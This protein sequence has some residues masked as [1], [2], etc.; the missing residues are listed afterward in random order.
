MDPLL[1][2]KFITTKEARELSGYTSD[3]LARLAR[4]G[5]LIG[6]RVGN[7]W[8]IEIESLTEFLDHQGNDKIVRARALARAREAEY[9]AH[10]STA[11]R[12]TS[13]LANK[14]KTAKHVDITQVSLRSHVVA[15][16]IAFA[17]IALGAAIAKSAALPKVAADAVSIA[18]EISSGFD[19]AFLDGISSN[20]VAN[21]DAAKNSEQT[22]PAHLAIT[23]PTTSLV[24]PASPFLANVAIAPVATGTAPIST[25]ETFHAKT[26]VT[27][28]FLATSQL[29][30]Y[31][32]TQ[33]YFALGFG[34]YSEIIKSLSIYETCIEDTAVG[35]FHFGIASRDF[36]AA[37]PKSAVRADVA[38]GNALIEATH[39]LIHA[40]VILAYWIAATAPES[41]HATVSF[42]GNTGNFFAISTA[43]APTRIESLYSETNSIP[44]AVIP[45]ITQIAFDAGY[46]GTSVIAHVAEPFSVDVP[47]SPENRGVKGGEP[48]V[49]SAFAAGPALSFGQQTALTT[50]NTFSALFGSTIRV[51][52][53]VFAP[54][55]VV[56]GTA[57]TSSAV[58]RP[59]VVATTTTK[60]SSTTRVVAMSSYPTY[61]TVVNGVSQNL[62]NQSLATLRAYILS[63]VAGEIQP[64]AVQGATNETTIQEVNMIQD[65]SNLTVRNG[66]FIGGTF[67]G[68]NIATNEFT[69]NGIATSTFANGINISSGCFAVNG[70][71]IGSGTGSGTVGSGAA[72]EF[73]YYAADG[74]ILSATSSLFIASTSNIG[75]GTANPMNA[76]DIANGGG[77]HIAAGVPASSAMAL[78]NNAGTLMWNG[79]ALSTGSSISGTQNYIPVFTGA[80]S[81]GNSVL[82]QA[83]N[84][85]GIGTTSPSQTLSVQG[86]GLFSGNLSVANFMATGTAAVNTLTLANA[87]G[88]TYGGTG[89]STAPTY[90]Q[91]LIGNGTGGYTFTS[92]SSLGI[93]S[94]LAFTY[95]LTNGANIISLAFGTTT[96]NTWGGTQTFLSAPVLGALTGIVAGNNGTLY[97]AATSSL[98]I[99]GSAG[100]VAYALTFSNGG[101]GAVSGIAYNGSSAYTISYNT[102]G[103]QQSNA[104][105]TSLAGLGFGSPAFVKMTGANTFSLDTNTYDSFAYPFPASATSSPIMLLASTTIGNGTAAGGLTINGNATTTGNASVAG[106]FTS[107]ALTASSAAIGSLTGP[108]QAINGVVSATSSLSVA[109]GGTGITNPSAAGILLGSYAGGGYQQLA[110]SS[111]GLLTTNVAEGT[112]LYF[113]N[114]RAIAAVL[115]GYASGPG[116]ISSADSVLSAIQKLNGNIGALNNI[117]YP[118]AL[119][120]NATSTLT[121]FNGGLTAYAST[122]IGNGTAAGGLTISGNA[123]TTGNA[124]VSG[125]FTLGSITGNLQAVNGVVSATSSLSVAYGGT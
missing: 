97:S 12:A 45:R 38:F 69:V 87:L 21:I 3:Y 58:S 101:A 54:L 94:A 33:T 113:T 47:V 83:V 90:G 124:Y 88:I 121:Q 72:G 125:T 118:F 92:T 53:D 34:A 109:Y 89:T 40:D 29:S 2:K 104:N 61:T 123:T 48:L 81:L 35:V 74:T 60:N 71:C 23:N 43:R 7:S 114:A 73:A 66:T 55:P 24:V 15:L 4:S 95:P 117:A 110:T 27:S 67:N 56:I 112:N 102:I 16:S 18:S 98:S 8:L 22:A 100:S 39:A 103:A 65:I 64:I 28:A 105:L 79:V 62:L 25:R 5:K 91:L 122:T 1:Q 44:A 106:T 99:G 19:D 68:S 32:L 96:N 52:G 116:V 26:R 107:G 51:I 36:I 11:R 119:A 10:R 37:I 57:E 63:T 76:L 30:P 50:Y 120:G 31:V 41:A 70:V 42:L 77:L 78:Y 75:I 82:Y 93:Q 111:L 20:I 115:T 13:A 14:F 17:V 84:N 108:L 85:L 49:A 9:R 80:N 86:N 6:S 59:V 46:L